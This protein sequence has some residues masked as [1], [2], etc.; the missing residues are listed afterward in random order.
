MNLLLRK[1]IELLSWIILY[2]VFSFIFQG[3][4]WFEKTSFMRVFTLPLTL[5]YLLIW[6]YFGYTRQLGFRK[7]ILVGLIGTVP[8]IFFTSIQAFMLLTGK[9]VT[10]TFFDIL[11]PSTV[12]LLWF[13]MA[14]QRWRLNLYY[15]PYL[16]TPLL[17]LLCAIGSYFGLQ[18]KV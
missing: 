10:G 1:G 7:G 2:C 4:L 16:L 18:N 6:F 11:N 9:D 8:T 14:F 15:M 3:L 13:S 12:P 17:A 5:G